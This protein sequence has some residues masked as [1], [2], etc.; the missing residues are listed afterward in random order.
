LVPV[1]VNS[2]GGSQRTPG[3]GEG[4]VHVHRGIHGIADLDASEYDWRNPMLDIVVEPAY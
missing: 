2:G 1:S 3:G 4:V